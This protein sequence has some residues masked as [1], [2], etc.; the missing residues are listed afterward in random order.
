MCEVVRP[1]LGLLHMECNAL[2]NFEA[3][4]ALCNLAGFEAP[5]KRSVSIIV[6]SIQ[7]LIVCYLYF[8]RIVKEKGFSK[9]ENYMYENHDMLK[10]ASVQAINNLLFDEEVIKMFEGKNDRTKYLFLLCTS[11]DI[12]LSKAAS[13]ALAILTSVSKRASRK[14]FEV[15]C[16]SPLQCSNVELAL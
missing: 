7:G 6:I 4:M 11:E 13:G 3:L 1:L 14:I 12:E 5:R 10:R 2:E 15:S 16:S 8:Y 9:I